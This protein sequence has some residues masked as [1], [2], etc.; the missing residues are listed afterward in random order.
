MKEP[1][2]REHIVAWLSSKGYQIRMAPHRGRPPSK[3]KG[4][5]RPSKSSADPDI[6]GRKGTTYYY[7]EAKG[8]P[9]STGQIYTAIGEICTKR[10]STTPTVFSVAFPV[11][12]VPFVLNLLSLRAWKK[13]DI[14]ILF[15]TTSGEVKEYAPSRASLDEI[16]QLLH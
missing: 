12:Y 7:V 16:K 1:R 2:V 6:K 10:A 9:P 5:G 11:S 15:V 8:D 3:T 4:K 13:L 14:R